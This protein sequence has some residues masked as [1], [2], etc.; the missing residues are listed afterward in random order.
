M[1]GT[2]LTPLVSAV[3]LST[4]FVGA[5][6]LTWLARRY[7]LSRKLIDLPNERS[8]HELPTPR[9]G[10]I[11]VVALT[12]SG[13]T[14]LWY[15]QVLDANTFFALISGGVLI[16]LAGWL[17]DH[18]KIGIIGR[19]MLQFVAATLAVYYLGGLASIQFAHHSFELGWVGKLV[20]VLGLMWL[21]NLYNFMDGIDGL[22]AIEA[23]F[24]G[25][26]GGILLS[27]QGSHGLAMVVLVLAS[28]NAGFI[29]WNW[30]PAQIFLG[31]V[32]SGFIGYMFGLV[33]LSGE[34]SNV[35]PGFLWIMILSVFIFDATFTLLRRIFTG[36]KWY[37]A[38]KCHAYQQ[39]VQ[40]GKSHRSVTLM[41]LVFNILVTSPLVLYAFFYPDL[42]WV[43]FM[44]IVVICL[45]LWILLTRKHM[46]QAG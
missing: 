32:G 25:V 22:A 9:G 15:W 1:S 35:M 8:S 43:M 26:L 12:L 27:L 41:I 14:V 23:V 7:A 30:P 36:Q 5:V 45:V 19:L 20:A 39:L 18:Q 21:S 44:L 33:T 6:A 10:G 34:V 31:D 38:H 28:A 13:A 40:R 24:V 46:S 16:A 2:I 3:L 4:I 29:F 42:A 37:Q 17:D 11:A